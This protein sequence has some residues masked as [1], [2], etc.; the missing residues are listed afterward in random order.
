MPGS[1]LID[2][3]PVINETISGLMIDFSL[4]NGRWFFKSFKDANSVAST[5][6]TKLSRSAYYSNL[7]FSSLSSFIAIIPMYADFS[8]SNE[9]SWFCFA[10]LTMIFYL[11]DRPTRMSRVMVWNEK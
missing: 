8:Y 10:N 5:Y 11:L 7:N 1:C 9:D 6:I 2:F 4:P 3:K